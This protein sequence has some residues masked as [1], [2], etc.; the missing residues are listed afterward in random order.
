MRTHTDRLLDE[1]KYFINCNG[2]Q[3]HD[4]LGA[5]TAS[6]K[7]AFIFWTYLRNETL[8]RRIVQDGWS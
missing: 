3:Q 5:F 6:S 7:N 8:N 1:I 4:Y 2:Y